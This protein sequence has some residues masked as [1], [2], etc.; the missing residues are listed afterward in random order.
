MMITDL[1]THTVASGHATRDTV[2][3]LA[4]EAAKRGLS[5]LGICDH[6]PKMPTGAKESYFRSLGYADKKLFGVRILYGVELNIYN[7]KGEVDLPEDILGKLDYTVASLHKDV[8]K[9]NTERVNTEAYVNAMNNKYVN[10]IGHPDDPTYEVDFYTL[11]ESAKET[12]TIIEVNSVGLDPDGYRRKN[13]GWLK[14]TVSLCKEK[15]V[16][17]SLGSDSHGK[18]KISDFGR[19][20]AFLKELDFPEDLVVNRD[21][22][23]FL[24]IVKSKRR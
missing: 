23:K 24:Q 11:V 10:I 14:E 15:G 17:I 12:G 18:E 3:D 1:H 16:Y 7:V 22:E 6:A 20:I 5:A 19:S 9:P 8:F 2:T 4:R 21:I 13:T